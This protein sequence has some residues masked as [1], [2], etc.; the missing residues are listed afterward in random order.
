M[1]NRGFT[2][3][4]LVGIILILALIFMVSFPALQSITKADSDKAYDKMVK[5]LCLAGESYIYANTD[6]FPNI[7]TIGEIITISVDELIVYGNVDKDLENPKTKTS[8][9]GDSLIYE[10]LSDYSLNCEYMDN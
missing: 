9:T 6:Y 4:E 2:I 1:D 10:V 3:I 5:K 7:S 8:V